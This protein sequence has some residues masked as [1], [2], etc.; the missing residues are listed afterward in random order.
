[1]G[2]GHVQIGATWIRGGYH[3]DEPQT[4]TDPVFIIDTAYCLWKH[5]L[6]GT[7]WRHVANII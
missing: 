4:S 1:M 6:F 2:V 7:D 3:E 5:A